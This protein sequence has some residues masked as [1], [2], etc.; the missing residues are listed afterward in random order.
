MAE[1]CDGSH[2]ETVSSMGWVGRNPEVRVA[3]L[4]GRVC[5]GV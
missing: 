1:M 5:L 4:V 3:G 2:V